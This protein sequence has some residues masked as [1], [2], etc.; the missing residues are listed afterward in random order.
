MRLW[1]YKL[2]P[3]LPRAQLLGQHRE[4]CALRGLGWGKNHSVVN[5]VFK[6]NYL[7]LYNYHKLVMIEM[8]RRGYKVTKLWL[9]KSYRG[10]R[11]P[12]IKDFKRKLPNYFLPYLET[13][14]EHNKT[15]LKECLDN[16]FKKGID[17]LVQ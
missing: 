1:H 3:I 2:L 9:D 4:C 17:L 15:Y 11:I 6:H 14:P 8:I 12:T 7:T 16:L 5:Y 10:Q 13:Y